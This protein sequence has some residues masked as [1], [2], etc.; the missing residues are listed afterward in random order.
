MSI[1]AWLSARTF[2]YP[3]VG[4]H[5]WVYLNWALGLRALGC[6]VIWL[7]AVSPRVPAHKVESRLCALK[8]WLKPYDLAESVALCSWTGEPLFP[9]MRGT[10]LDLEAAPEADLILNLAY[11]H[12][13]IVG[14][15]RRSALVDIDPGLTQIWMNEGQIR[16]GRHDLYFTIGETVG[17]PGARFPDCGLS[18]QYTPPCV[19]LEW[20]PQRKATMGGRFT[21]VSN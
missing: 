19:A 9:A 21:T 6:Q 12:P 16:V 10:C 4:G 8:R 14:R 17:L 2:N 11:V 3:Q 15:F 1:T 13:E 5:F 20:W 18:W 7:E